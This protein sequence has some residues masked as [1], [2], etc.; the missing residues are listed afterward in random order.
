MSSFVPVTMID[1][2]KGKVQWVCPEC[3]EENI[4]YLYTQLF[5]MMSEL[6]CNCGC[7]IRQVLPFTVVQHGVRKER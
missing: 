5:L 7:V 2:N 6:T 1:Q 3:G 4:G